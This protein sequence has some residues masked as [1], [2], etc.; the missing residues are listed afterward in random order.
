MWKEIMSLFKGGGLCK[1]AFDEAMLMLSESRTM[2]LDA[3]EA[4]HSPGALVADIYERDRQ[5]NRYERSVRRRIVTHLSISESPDVNMALVLTAIVIDIERIGDYTKNIAELASVLEAPFD[6]L[7]LG[8]DI[9]EVESLVEDTFGNIAR[10][11]EESDEDGARTIMAAH[12]RVAELVDRD[13]VRL[14]RSEVLAGRSG[15]AVTVALYLRFL[16]RVSAHLKNIASSV[17]N[18]YDR[19]GFREKDTEP[20]PDAPS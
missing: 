12:G 10:V 5:I 2:Y 1:E 17:V 6:G 11:L 15:H 8:E 14:Q 4:L 9:A 16:K 13:V 7:E 20:A 18:P 19:I 3:V